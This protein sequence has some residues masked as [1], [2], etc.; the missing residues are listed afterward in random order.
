V[1]GFSYFYLIINPMANFDPDSES[2]TIPFSRYKLTGLLLICLGFAAV[3]IWCI[4]DREAISAGSL[5]HDPVFFAMFIGVVCIAFAGMGCSVFLYQLFNRKPGL[6]VDINGIR[7]NSTLASVGLIKWDDITEVTEGSAAG[8]VYIHVKN[9]EAYINRF[10][11]RWKKKFAKANFDK[12]GTPL[13]IS[14]NE[15]KCDFNE[16]YALL[17]ARVFE[18][19]EAKKDT[20]F[21]GSL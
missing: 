19:Q 14:Q 17:T 10:N 9:P 15:L 20:H 2:V 1:P 3:G 12:N 4:I 13:A 6:V 8:F 21:H 7:D 5:H 11:N 18:Y 16:L